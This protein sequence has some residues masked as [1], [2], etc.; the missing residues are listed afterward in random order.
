MGLVILFLGSEFKCGA[1]FFFFFLDFLLESGPDTETVR[2][3]RC[4]SDTQSPSASEGYGNFMSFLFFCGISE[5]LD[6]FDKC[7]TALVVCIWGWGIM[8]TTFA[9]RFQEMCPCVYLCALAPHA[10]THSIH[11]SVVCVYH[12]LQCLNKTDCN[13]LLLSTQLVNAMT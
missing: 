11:Y 4:F 7:V 9:V 3:T 12:A 2:Q 5:K 8:L 6:V 13:D 1:F 10:S